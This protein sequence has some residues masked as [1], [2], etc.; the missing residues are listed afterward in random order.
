MGIY[1]KAAL[2]EAI[3]GGQQF[4][5]LLFYGH[6]QNADG[7]VS[8]SCFSQWFPAKFEIDGIKYPTAEHF[9]MAEKARLFGDDEMLEKIVQCATPKEAKAFGRKV[10]NFDDEMWKKRCSRSNGQHHKQYHYNHDSKH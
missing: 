9:M 8:N 5:Y 1:S 6:R 7:S 3:E 10:R 2:L 4:E